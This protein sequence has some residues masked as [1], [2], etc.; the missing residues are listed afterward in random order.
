MDYKFYRSKKYW[1][2]L[3]ISFGQG[4]KKNYLIVASIVVVLQNVR[5]DQ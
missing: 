3:S 5:M 1:E 2:N 4:D